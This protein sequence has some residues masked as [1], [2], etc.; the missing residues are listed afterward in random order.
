M[1]CNVCW[2]NLEG[3]GV[4]TNCGHVF[5]VEDA[6]RILHSDSTC[7]LCE[8]ILSKSDMK[9][10]DLNPKEEWVNMAMAGVPPDYIMKSAFKGVVFWLGQKDVEAQVTVSK[11]M[12]LRQKFEEMQTKY[13][14][15]LQQVHAGYQKAMKK[16]QCVQ[17]EKDS[18]LKDRKEL[19]EKYAE[20]ARQKRKL[21]EMYETLRGEYEKV[22]RTALVPGSRSPPFQKSNQFDFTAPTPSGFEDRTQLRTSDSER[23]MEF[24]G[25]APGTP[26]PNSQMWPARQKPVSGLFDGPSHPAIRRRDQSGRLQK[27]E[28]G[29]SPFKKSDPPLFTLDGGITSTGIRNMLLSPMKRPASRMP[30]SGFS[31]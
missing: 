31:S 18:L 8:K 12:Q 5:C 26:A 4:A 10:V 29:S 20:K 24:L 6:T 1:K 25:L 13:M 27:N 21:E 19:Q 14:E 11:A 23:P 16:L 17:E 28:A 30:P 9:A 3:R 22:K 15:K 7:P 2:R